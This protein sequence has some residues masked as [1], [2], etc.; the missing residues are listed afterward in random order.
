M[1]SAEAIRS[2]QELGREHWGSS[3][4]ASG[5][6]NV[7]Q[8]ER[9]ACQ[10]GGGVLMAVGLLRG[11]L[12]GLALAGLGGALLYRGSSG[13]CS[14]YQALGISTAEG[15]GPMA[16]LTSGEGVHVEEEAYIQRSPEEL[17]RFWREY[18]NLPRFMTDVESVTPLGSNDRSHW[19]VK[20]PL[21][22]AME[23]DAEIHQETPG[24]MIAW[25][26]LPGGDVATAGSVHFQPAMGGRGTQVRVNERFSLPGGPIGVAVARLF[27]QDPATRTRE[28]LRRLKTLMESTPA[29]S[30]A[31]A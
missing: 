31:T 10:V 15:R 30:P 11:G 14:L 19:V 24:E 8:D 1:A 9:L 18:H 27:G 4:R 21:G 13:S 25:R 26:S 12:K 6:V 20:G 7:G 17:F 3:R 16:S 29:A 2:S 22:L 5:P 28:S 23:W